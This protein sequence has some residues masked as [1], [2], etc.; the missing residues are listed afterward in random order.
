MAEKR[1][2]LGKTNSRRSREQIDKLQKEQGATVPGR[3]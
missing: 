3:G 1:G 2:D